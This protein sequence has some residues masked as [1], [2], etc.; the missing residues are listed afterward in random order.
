MPWLCGCHQKGSPCSPDAGFQQ[1]LLSWLPEDHDKQRGSSRAV[2]RHWCSAK[3]TPK[4]PPVFPGNRPSYLS[5]C[6]GVTC[7]LLEWHTSRALVGC[8]LQT[9]A[10][11][12]HLRVL[13]LPH[14]RLQVSPNEELT[15]SFVSPIFAAGAQG[16]SPLDH[17]ALMV[18]RT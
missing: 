14:S 1:G 13:P 17:L 5:W 18:S 4:H 2:P 9:E 7:R 3:S 10:G 6:F 8:S 16:T 15:D 11:K 12:C